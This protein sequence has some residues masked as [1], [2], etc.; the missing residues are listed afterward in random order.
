MQGPGHQRGTALVTALL[1]LALTVTLT[2]DMAREQQFDI[3]RTGNLLTLAQA[4]QIALGGERWAVAILARD[5]RGEGAP[6]QELI[7]AGGSG[8]VDS[9]DEDWAQPLPPIPVEGGQ[10]AGEIVD[11][12]GR[13]NVNNLVVDGAVDAVATAR[14]ERLLEAVEIYPLAAQSVIDWLDE[15]SETTS[16][17]GAEDAYYAA[18]SPP[19]LAANRPVVVISELRL[20]RGITAEQWRRL[21]SHVTALPGSTEIN[22][23]TASAPV[24]QALIPDLDPGTAEQIVGRAREEPFE[25]VQEFLE[26]DVFAGLEV[27]P[28]RIAVRSSH[29]RVRS[30]VLLGEIE[31]TLYSWLRRSDNGAS[32]VLRRAR[33]AD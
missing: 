4:H 20:L 13:F 16:P 22:V 10:I 6:G 24:L 21:A 30:A 23:N 26:Q 12:Q 19:R 15:D 32:S 25:S 11:L 18:A 31:Y 28:T 7:G 17:N 14:F 8:E 1:V 5:A 3:R 33:L 2:T 27:D 29:F 9:L